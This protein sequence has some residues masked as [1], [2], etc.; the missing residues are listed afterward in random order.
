MN[1]IYREAVFDEKIKSLFNKLNHHNNFDLIIGIPFYDEKEELVQL[2]KWVDLQL[3]NWKSRRQLIVCAGDST[4]SESLE[5]LQKTP[6]QHEHIYFLMPE[7]ASGRGMSIRAFLALASKFEADLLILDAG[8]AGKDVNNQPAYLENMLTPVHGHYDMVIGS[9]RGSIGNDIITQIF[10][11]PILEAFYGARIGDPLAG[12]YAISHDFAEELN[13]EAKFWTTIIGGYG[14]DFWLITRCLVWNKSLCEYYMQGNIKQP[15]W[16][17]ENEIFQ[18]IAGSLLE[19]IRRDSAVCLQSRLI[20]KVP[21]LLVRSKIEKPDEFNYSFAEVWLGFTEVYKK[22]RAELSSWLNE[23]LLKQLDRLMNSEGELRLKDDIWVKACNM[24]LLAYTFGPEEKRKTLLSVLTALYN[25]RVAA[26]LREMENFQK[27]I[28]CLA[29]ENRNHLLLKQMNLIR[30]RIA[31][32]FWN[33]KP[34]LIRWW[35]DRNETTRPPIIPLH[36]ME[37][38]PGRPIVIPKQIT[39]K[40]NRQVQTDVIYKRLRQSYEN[41]LSHFLES[42]IGLSLKN[43]SSELLNG[44]SRFMDR[45]ENMLTELLPGDLH[46]PSGLQEFVKALFSLVPHG[47]MFTVRADLLREMLIRFPPVNIMIPLGY[48]TAEALID[49]MDIRDAVSY[50]NLVDE[51]SYTDRDLIWLLEQIKPESFEWTDIKPLILEKD[52]RYSSLTYTK[53]S[54]LNRITARIAVKPLEEGRGGRYPRIRYF[55]ALIRRLVLAEHYSELFSLSARERKNVGQKVKNAMLKVQKGDEFSAYNIF[56]N[57]HHRGMVEKIKELAE[58]MASINTEYAQIFNLLAAG[59]GV[60]QVLSDHTFLTCTAWSWA[61]YSYKGGRRF[62]GPLTT[63]IESRWFAHDFLEELYRELGYDVDEITQT[64]FRWINSGRSHQ[65]LLDA[66]LPARPRDVAVV[67]QEIT[68]EPSKT[69]Q[70]FS[71]N[72]LLEVN[73]EHSW[74]NKYVLNPGA[75]RIKDKVYLFY[76]AVGDD[77]V[78]HIGLAITDGYNVI[79]RLPEPIFSPAIPEEAKGCEDPRLII[80]NDRIWMLY[81]AYDGNIAQIAAASITVSDFLDR[82]F[83][84]KREGLA[85]KNIW[86]KDAILF[87][88][89]INNKYI[90]YHRIEPSMWVTYLDEVAFP[91]WEKHAIILGPRP[92]HT[93]DSLKIGAGAQ[94]LK[95]IYGWLLIYHGVDHNYVYRLGVILVDLHN[96]QKVLYRSPNP[97]L[98]PVEDYEI[99][100]SGAWVPNVVFTCGAVAGTDKEILEDDDQILVYYGA[101]DTSIGMASARLADLIPE[102]FRRRAL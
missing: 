85:F 90:L 40:D 60:G 100:L 55:Y 6:L 47:K 54:N 92:G 44:V 96:P 3:Q 91:C 58:R 86:N 31:E 67:V 71:G 7:E 61:S 94:P 69:L 4:S 59:Y 78:S 36:Y 76:R 49:N 53:I 26:Y 70:R 56:E 28:S 11:S 82:N 16:E 101:A 34:D 22:F 64:V 62:P 18:E 99:G 83:N 41:K 81:T 32:Q 37:Y 79:E 38:V 75:L 50:A 65:S 14:I 12:I 52:L 74:E 29:E 1:R 23:D 9:L 72:P 63:S 10:A 13:S 48:Y 102:K 20:I 73:P 84:W 51:W 8:M 39:G 2:L 43:N 15:S 93:W 45:A 57:Y 80:I 68:D 21:D 5:L 88:E 98:E 42:G 95:T 17:R 35:Q 30:S 87:P 24:L 46:T 33:Q 25:G 66:A 89:K 19:A 97:I 77:D 27:E